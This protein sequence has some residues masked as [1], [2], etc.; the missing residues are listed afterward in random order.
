MLS[1]EGKSAVNSQKEKKK[2]FSFLLKIRA[3]RIL[4]K[5]KQSTS[6]ET[7]YKFKKHERKGLHEALKSDKSEPNQISKCIKKST[8]SQVSQN[9]TD[10]IDH[11]LSISLSDEK[12]I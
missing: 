8:K 7:N 9:M 12:Q 2:I 1:E 6:T 10:E 5:Q 11:P 3:K 4:K